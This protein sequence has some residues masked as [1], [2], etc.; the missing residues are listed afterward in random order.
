MKF[1]HDVVLPDGK[2]LNTICGKSSIREAND[3]SHDKKIASIEEKIYHLPTVYQTF[4][5]CHVYVVFSE[6]CNLNCIYCFENNLRIDSKL[7]NSS[8]ELA[9]IYVQ[10]IH[11]LEKSYKIV[12]VTLYG[13]EPLLA[14]NKEA[15]RIILDYCH[16][17]KIEVRIITNGVLLDC[18]L[19]IM[20]NYDCISEIIITIDGEKDVHNSRRKGKGI[21]DT[22]D[23]IIRNIR[24]AVQLQLFTIVIRVNL[25][26][27]NIFYQ[28]QMIFDLEKISTEKI[29]I[30]YYRTQ[31]NKDTYA[32]NKLLSL[33]AFASFMDR[34]LSQNFKIKIKSGENTYNQI[35]DIL[36]KDKQIYPRLTYCEYGYI[37]L[38]AQDGNIYSCEEGIGVSA[39][40][41]ATIHDFIES[42]INL[43]Q[44][45]ADSIVQGSV[46]SGCCTCTVNT[47][48][49]GG[50]YLKR[51]RKL[52][53]CD[54]EEIRKT[55]DEMYMRRK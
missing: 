39:C 48:C 23:L 42:P 1:P 47:I 25:D 16:K 24:E 2:I 9:K 19:P 52:G 46:K 43:R 50:C 37:Y 31:N 13:G 15:I 54:K 29:E 55:L 12:K 26:L 6:K 35:K 44:N 4:D 17:N 30:L 27:D 36:E 45:P 40:A 18:Y 3:T 22:Y 41:Y 21:R 38:L 49:G 7:A 5:I 51:L 34:L 32:N 10:C 28:R 14:E 20:N 11:R 33:S 53:Y 8:E